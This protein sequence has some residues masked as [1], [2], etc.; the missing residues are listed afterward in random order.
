N[1]LSSL[2]SKVSRANLDG[3]VP[4]G[5]P[6]ADGP[7]GNNDYIWARGFRNPFSF[8]FQPETGELWVNC[9]G[10]SYEQVFLVHAGDHA[11]W[12][13]YENDQPDGYI[14]P[15]IKYVTNG[16]DTRNIA[17]GAGAVR[18]NNVATFTTTAPHGFRQ[19]EKLTITGV[20]DG[21]F[22]GSFYAASVTGDT[23]F[24]VAQA[25]ADG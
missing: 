2:A 3:S 15:K 22:N 1:N 25:G 18:S 12:T 11:G 14:K 7:G 20:T 23:N 21:S 17:A 24:T 13:A 16:S 10:T 6:F 5:N 4:A 8:T 19:G 9:V